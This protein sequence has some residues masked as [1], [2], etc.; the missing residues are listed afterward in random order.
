MSVSRPAIAVVIGLLV[1]LAVIV[2]LAWLINTRDWG[3]V[4]M[5]LMPFVIYGLI[6]IARGLARWANPPP[7]MPTHDSG[8]GS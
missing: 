3:V 1:S 7:D 2:P 4:L 5:L 8:D 6:R